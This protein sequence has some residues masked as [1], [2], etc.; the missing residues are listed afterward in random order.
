MYSSYYSSY[1]D[2]YS[3]L[4]LVIGM[5]QKEY[6]PH[7]L[8]ASLG[9]NEML[10][11]RNVYIW[12]FYSALNIIG[13]GNLSSGTMLLSLSLVIKALEGRQHKITFGSF[14]MLSLDQ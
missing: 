2:S 1:L 13:R 4:L 9:R 12:S 10:P 3:S 11:E 8:R 7:V 5:V 6:I 14:Q